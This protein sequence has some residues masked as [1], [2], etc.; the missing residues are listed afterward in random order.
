[1]TWIESS[2]G[3]RLAT[4]KATTALVAATPERLSAALAWIL[5]AATPDVDADAPRMTDSL[6]AN[7]AS[8]PAVATEP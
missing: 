3:S 1:M 5:S 8:A 6:R 2:A 4:A 7:A